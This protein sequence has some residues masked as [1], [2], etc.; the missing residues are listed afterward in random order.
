MKKVKAF[1]VSL[2][3]VVMCLFC[4]VACGEKGK[5]EVVSYTVGGFKQEV[6][7]DDS[8]YIELKSDDVAVVYIKFGTM[9]WEGEGTWAKDED[10][11]D[12]V[13]ITVGGITYSATI[14]GDTMT[15]NMIVGSIV[16]EK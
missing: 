15:L 8:S 13:N 10:K 7:D 4:L 6:S 14:D 2:L 9:S 1:F 16:L 5:Y 3:A 11:D 12:T